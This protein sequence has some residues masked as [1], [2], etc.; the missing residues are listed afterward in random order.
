MPKEPGIAP[1]W[2]DWP[3]QILSSAIIA[4]YNVP[5]LLHGASEKTVSS[6]HWT[7]CNCNVMFSVI[8]LL[9]YIITTK[10]PLYFVI[11]NFKK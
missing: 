10:T 8:I 6:G 9:V 7:S 2:I 4:I 11:V 1:D 3:D 5:I